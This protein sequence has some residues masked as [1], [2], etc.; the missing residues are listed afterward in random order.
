MKHIGWKTVL[1]AAG[2]IYIALTLFGGIVSPAFGIV[3]VTIAVYVL[4]VDRRARH[5][6]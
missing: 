1:A 4:I 6:S 5:K 2:L 3:Y